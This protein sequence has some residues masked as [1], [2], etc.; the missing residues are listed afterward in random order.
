MDEP[1]P[2]STFHGAFSTISPTPSLSENDILQKRRRCFSASVHDD[3]PHERRWGLLGSFLPQQHWD[4]LSSWLHLQTA[5][6][7]LKGLAPVV[8]SIS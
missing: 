5:I 2:H 6:K 7:V 4:S 8:I 3:L 1:P